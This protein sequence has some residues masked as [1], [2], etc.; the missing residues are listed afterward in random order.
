[1]KPF[2][3]KLAELLYG[4]YGENI[5]S[6][7]FIF[8]SRRAG[9]YFKNYLSELIKKPVWSPV[10]CGISDF[11]NDNSE[12]KTA[13]EL[14]LIFELYSVYCKHSSDVSFDKFYPWGAII[15]R[16][17]DEMDKNLV[18]A[19]HIFRILKEH[20]KIEED[21]EFKAADIDEFYRFWKSFSARELNSLQDEF[22]KT[23]EI[24]GKV[25]HD[26]RRLLISKN[27][28][29][30]G[31][32]YRKI[33][34]NVV[35]G[36]FKINFNKYVFAG[37]NQLNK[38]EEGIIKQLIK[39]H[40]AEIYWDTDNFYLNDESKEAGKF[41]RKNFVELGIDSPQWKEN[42]LA[43]SELNL[44]I[45]GSPLEVSQAKVLGNELAGLNNINSIKTAIILPDDTLLIPVLHSIP[46]NI[47]KINITMG[48]AFKNS[49]LF[50][51]INSLK[52]LQLNIKGNNK[53]AVFYHK[54]IIN[55]LLHPYIRTANV[56]E[57]NKVVNSINKHN[58]VYISQSALLKLFIEPPDIIS[59][60]FKDATNAEDTY[61]YI[62]NII[63]KLYKNIDSKNGSYN[64]EIEFLNNAYNEL[65]RIKDLVVN[66]GPE[67][68]KETFLNILMECF[69]RIKIP[70]SGLPLEGVQIMGM[71]EARSLDFDNV[72]ILSVNENILPPDTG[73]SS[74]IPFA[75]K[76]AF[77]LPLNED[78]EADYAYYFFRLLQRAKN[79]T[80]IYNTETGV[81]SAGEKSRFILQIQNEL[82]DFNKK[83]KIEELLLSCDI[84]LPA[85]KEI[86]ISK[87]D[88]VLNL[89]KNEKQYSATTLSAYINCPLQFYFKKAAKLKKDEEVEEYFS[90]AAFGNIF[91][92][93][94]HYIYSND[95]GKEVTDEEIEKKIFIIKN[96][97][98]EVWKKVCYELK[99]YSEFADIKY[100][101]NLLYKR[102]IKKLVI[103]VL[104]CDKQQVPFMIVSLEKAAEREITVNANG[105]KIIVKLIGRLDRVEYKN[106]I[107]RII[108]Y[109]SGNA[110]LSKNSSKISD[111]E[112]INDLFV[113]IKRKENFQQLFYASLYFYE[114]INS[115]L[116]VGVY[117]LKKLA[118]GVHWFEEEPITVDKYN[119]FESKLIDLFE[120]IF[121]N[122]IPFTQTKETDH[123]MYCPYISICYRD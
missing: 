98:D 58:I 16:D 48:Y 19:D 22:I 46:D 47:E 110:D 94:M 119:L 121:D 7:Q 101:K 17:F 40:N 74:F 63:L 115:Q 3:Q 20:K 56:Y 11:I 26:F 54:D 9:L 111:E 113:N 57:I 75:L 14:T 10:T 37:F 73:S 8:P 88:E 116:I 95:L 104:L 108:D 32:S 24:L 87:T 21:F 15:L 68:S 64:Y 1:M 114:Q 50:S 30:E 72:Y 102:V 99:E 36:K 92:Q 85:R 105:E 38:S 23:W 118:G 45:I 33:H 53:S 123:C 96:D 71:L 44:K 76:K 41:L 86:T 77:G 55:L 25:Y 35:T 2:L 80:L 29:Y 90:A 89:L 81:I 109:K 97:F 60:V 28:C 91:H 112:Y 5:S 69:R 27:I 42:N 65:N 52:E 122:N 83:I 12:Y 39:T 117:P 100:G 120:E 59:H 82:A 67:L 66:Y 61:N 49:I 93:I 43:I 103:K 18:Q 4:K 51:L 107:T 62:Y 31:M 34:D 79:V 70:F 84:V 106:N 6:L 78:T 13:D